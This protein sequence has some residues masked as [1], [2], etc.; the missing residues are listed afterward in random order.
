MN[1][2]DFPEGFGTLEFVRNE[3]IKLAH[4]LGEGAF[5]IVNYGRLLGTT[6]GAFK[7]VAV[8]HLRAKVARQP[9]EL[10]RFLREAHALSCLDCPCVP[11]TG[12]CC[13][14]CDPS[15]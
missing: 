13:A 11:D 1:L 4:Y 15:I 10:T 12:F 14:A 7:G 3:D 6:P 9:E 8:K 5:S 2:E